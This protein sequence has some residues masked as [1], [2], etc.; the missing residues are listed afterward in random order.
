MLRKLTTVVCL[1][2][3]TLSI[4]SVPVDAARAKKRPMVRPTIKLTS[5]TAGTYS[6]TIP[7]RWQFTGSENH[8]VSI[9]VM[10]MTFGVPGASTF[11][12][13][14]HPIG[15]NGAGSYTWTPGEKH[16]GK[17]VIILVGIE[18]NSKVTSQS[19]TIT[20]AS[21]PGSGQ[22]SR[23]TPAKTGSYTQLLTHPSSDN[24]RPSYAMNYFFGM[25]G[26]SPQKAKITRVTNTSQTGFRL[27]FTDKAGRISS[28]VDLSPG[29]STTAFNNMTNW[30]GIWE[31][32]APFPL[33]NLL[34]LKVEWSE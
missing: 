8:K 30:G 16:K 18:D 6:T 3:F 17:K 20:I 10:S 26:S 23:Q 29:A 12:V 27:W 21:A 34:K 32:A 19:A 22:S 11:I 28:N 24:G 4:L 25:S 15:V 9:M 31:A 13:R 7:I 5:P 14:N 33:P 2:L 1:I